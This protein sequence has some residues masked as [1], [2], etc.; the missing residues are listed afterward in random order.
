MPFFSHSTENL[1]KFVEDLL[2]GKMGA[3]VKSAPLPE[4]NDGPVKV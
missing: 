3:Y 1:E 4:S 2:A